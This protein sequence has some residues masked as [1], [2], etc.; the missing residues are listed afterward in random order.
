M[1]VRGRWATPA[2]FPAPF[3]FDRCSCFLMSL[4]RCMAGQ[5]RVG[6]ARM[7]AVTIAMLRE[8]TQR[9]VVAR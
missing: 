1:E 3:V 8:K 2:A 6:G 9:P 4:Q 7:L 5:G